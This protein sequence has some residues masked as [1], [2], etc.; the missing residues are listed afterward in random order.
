MTTAK[1]TINRGH[2][3]DQQDFAYPAARFN[4]KECLLV[5]GEDALRTHCTSL[6]P[7]NE[8]GKLFGEVPF[9]FF[10]LA[11]S[12]WAFFKFE[13]TLSAHALSNPPP[14]PPLILETLP[15]ILVTYAIPN[16]PYSPT[17]SLSIKKG[18]FVVLFRSPQAT[19]SNWHSWKALEE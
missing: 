14:P 16:L 12:I 7:S 19:V 2:Q 17:P 13:P 8:I 4:E 5:W 1:W 11:K 6:A 9:Q 18:N 3:R 15:P 10:M